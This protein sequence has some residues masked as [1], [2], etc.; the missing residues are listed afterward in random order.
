V[1]FDVDALP[2]AICRAVS[3][4]V[5]DLALAEGGFNRVLQTTFND[6]YA[7]I[8]RIPYHTTVP[9]YRA[10]ASEA[11][12]L[13]L[14]RSRGVPVPKV[15]G[16]SPD[17]TNPVGT[18]YLLLEK[19]D[20]TPLSDQWFTMDNKTRVKI[21]RQIVDVEKQFMSISLPASGSLSYRRD[22]GESE[23]AIP[24]SEQSASDQI[25]VGPTAQFE[26]WY[27]ERALLDV[28]RGPCTSFR[29]LDADD[30]Y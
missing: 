26:W 9:K 19:L 20:G 12:T 5:S 27:R 21:T 17:H 14:L 13:D 7:V 25:V 10:V 29:P 3:R 16:Y 8:A 6:D 4:P 23:F 28:D 24:L 15:L 11:A 2:T 22:L 30:I 18:E 1:Q